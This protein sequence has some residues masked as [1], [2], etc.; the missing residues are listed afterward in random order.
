MALSLSGDH[1]RTARGARPGGTLSLEG[2]ERSLIPH[3]CTEFLPTG[4]RRR[5]V[6]PNLPDLD[7]LIEIAYGPAS[8]RRGNGFVAIHLPRDVDLQVAIALL[9]RATGRIDLAAPVQ[10]RRLSGGDQGRVD[11]GQPGGDDES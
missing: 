5:L 11:E 9:G 3:Q 1:V 8:T 10:G 6:H 4:G 7:V 2:R